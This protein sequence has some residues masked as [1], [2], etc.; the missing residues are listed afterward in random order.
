MWVVRDGGGGNIEN[1]L[2]NPD[3]NSAKFNSYLG[4]LLEKLH[5]GSSHP[6][7][8]E[9]HVI[10]HAFLGAVADNLSPME[11]TAAF[12]A[13]FYYEHREAIRHG[14]SL[15][16]AE[17][18]SPLTQQ[19]AREQGYE[20]YN[21]VYLNQFVAKDGTRPWGTYPDDFAIT[22]DIGKLEKLAEK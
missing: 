10:W 6:L 19:M 2:Q 17:S 5:G 12:D 16:L 3:S 14:F 9:K 15:I 22:L 20:L 7:P 18:A 1:L 21:T 13:L 11:K 8:T 4:E